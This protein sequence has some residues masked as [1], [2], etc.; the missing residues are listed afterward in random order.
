MTA[1]AQRAAAVDAST[2]RL[3]GRRERLVYAAEQNARYAARAQPDTGER[4]LA[5]G[6]IIITV[7]LAGVI[8]SVAIF[9]DADTGFSSETRVMN[10][11][12]SAR[13]VRRCD[14]SDCRFPS[15]IRTVDPG[16]IVTLGDPGAVSGRYIVTDGQGKTL[17]CFEV[18]YFGGTV[19]NTRL[20]SQLDPCPAGTPRY[21]G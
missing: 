4:G 16:E 14:T 1:L 10:D 3:R 2:E 6:A 7:L 20:L 13:L 9:A 15:A 18:E 21:F 12:A 11:G 8:A 17:G 19:V 5:I